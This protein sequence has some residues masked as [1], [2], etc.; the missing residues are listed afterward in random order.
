MKEGEDQKDGTSLIR[1]NMDRD[2]LET[3]KES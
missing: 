3:Y 2:L 1:R